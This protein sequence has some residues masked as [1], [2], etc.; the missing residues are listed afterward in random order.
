MSI[1]KKRH[2]RPNLEATVGG[3]KCCVIYTR[4]SDTSEDGNEISHQFQEEAC[5]KKAEAQGYEVLEV[6]RDNFSG[7]YLHER[8]GM[9]RLR[10]LVRTGA[11]DAVFVWKFDRISRRL[12]QRVVL[13]Q[14][15]KEHHCQHLSATEDIA[16]TPEGR[17]LEAVLAA[18]A[19]FEVERTLERSQA[20][21]DVL[22]KRG[23]LIC[24]GYARYGYRY[25]VETR[26]RVIVEVEARWVRQI[27]EWYLLGDS[28]ETIAARLTSLQVATPSMTRNVKASSPVWSS[29]A[30]RRILKEESYT[31]TPMVSGKIRCTGEPGPNGNGRREWTPESQWWKAKAPTPKIIERADF[32][33]AQE[34][35]AGRASY[36]TSASKES[37]YLLRGM[38]DCGV[39]GCS[40][41]PNPT[42]N[43]HG[44]TYHYFTCISRKLPGVGACGN[45]PMPMPPLED[46]VWSKVVELLK[47]KK[48][49]ERR[50]RQ[51]AQ[52]ANLGDMERDSAAHEREIEAAR[53][54][55]KRVL[56]RLAETDDIEIVQPLE[57]RLAELR[58]AITAHQSERAR[59]EGKLSVIRNQ[60]TTIKRWQEACARGL[61]RL[62]HNASVEERRHLLVS[63]DVRV[64][65]AEREVTSLQLG[66]PEGVGNSED[67]PRGAYR[68]P[69]PLLRFELVSA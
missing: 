7:R 26:T 23:D 33:R 67:P 40:M 37:P 58:Q 20:G 17:L 16:D 2:R 66:I 69:N 21:L 4:V 6:F 48:A 65:V 55:I 15:L 51:M 57:A 50:F 53:A 36:D 1:P 56:A 5:R 63:L 14:E 41:T 10:E 38:V 31:G 25:D 9:S 8:P 45:R 28:T 24:G 11:V 22:R 49:I 60:E 54:G 32:D 3:R 64:A 62:E 29:A 46:Y 12:G 13:I 47:D 68:I 52:A 43:R 39:C 34:I 42:R 44:K 35:L 27:F 59:I 19:E 30:V 61:E 18:I